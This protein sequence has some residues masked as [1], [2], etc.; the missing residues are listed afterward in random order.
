MVFIVTV[1]TAVIIYMVYKGYQR[2][3]DNF[4][5]PPTI[6]IE[7]PT[8]LPLAVNKVD[9]DNDLSDI[10]TVRYEKPP[11]VSQSVE[12][13]SAKP[14]LKK[15]HQSVKTNKLSQEVYKWN[16]SYTEAHVKKKYSDHSR[17]PSCYP[18]GE[19]V[20]SLSDNEGDMYDHVVSPSNT[21]KRR[22]MSLSDLTSISKE[23]P[24]G[25]LLQI[26]SFLDNIHAKHLPKHLNLKPKSSPPAMEMD[27]DM[28]DLYDGTLRCNTRDRSNMLPSYA[29]FNVRLSGMA[30]SL[31]THND[32]ELT[33]TT[34]KESRKSDTSARPVTQYVN[35]EIVEQH[36][37]SMASDTVDMVDRVQSPPQEQILKFRDIQEE[38]PAYVTMKPASGKR[39]LPDLSKYFT[40]NERPPLTKPLSLLDNPVDIG[41][42][43]EL[44]NLDTQWRPISVDI[45]HVISDSEA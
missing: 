20:G 21:D 2:K 39:S 34:K 30:F 9:N 22:S 45:D 6:V 43:I 1:V 16:R 7:N 26:P 15:N 12:Q 38:E 23:V 19:Y 27:D 40:Q 41:P 5:A 32:S 11:S 8:V 13:L 10:P 3:K 31:D 17:I 28:A 37:E 44:V 33:A 18:I 25:S 36:R 42:P 24:N 35:C 29:P 14:K 4:I